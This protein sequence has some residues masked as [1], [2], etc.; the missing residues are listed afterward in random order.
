MVYRNMYSAVDESEVRVGSEGAWRG[1]DQGTHSQASPSKTGAD[2]GNVDVHVHVQDAHVLVEANLNMVSQRQRNL[3]HLNCHQSLDDPN[4]DQL[5]EEDSSRDSK[6]FPRAEGQDERDRG[7][8]EQ[9]YGVETMT[10]EIDNLRAELQARDRM[11]GSLHLENEDLRVEM[12]EKDRLLEALRE[13]KEELSTQLE[14]KDKELD[15]LRGVKTDSDHGILD[16]R[17]VENADTENKGSLDRHAVEGGARDFPDAE[18]SNA[19]E[20]SDHGSESRHIA[21]K[22]RDADR[23]TLEKLTL[24]KEALEKEAQDREALQKELLE[25]QEALEVECQRLLD[26]NEDLSVDCRRLGEE[27]AKVLKEI[28]QRNEENGDL[29]TECAELKNEM[30][31]LK[32]E[33]EAAAK[34]N[35][36]L[37]AT[38]TQ[39]QNEIENLKVI[40][41]YVHVCVCM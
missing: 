26:E 13:D 5:T 41:M 18:M 10:L 11:L 16:D 29:T 14:S 38:C 8:R 40:C 15:S 6:D 22:E 27:R 32:A 28:A 36:A 31:Q 35:D 23:Q 4:S 21:I 3:H 12:D 17:Q 37:Q 9:N 1:P 25:R 34:D 33:K 20:E 24:E 39:L 7:A 30:E 19:H 2:V